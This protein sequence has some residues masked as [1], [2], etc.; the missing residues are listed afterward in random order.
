M[1]AN[2]SLWRAEIK[3]AISVLLFITILFWKVKPLIYEYW[4]TFFEITVWSHFAVWFTEARNIQESSWI[5]YLQKTRVIHSSSIYLRLIGWNPFLHLSCLWQS[6]IDR[7][8][9][10]HGQFI[11][12]HEFFDLL[13]E[14]GK[15]KNVVI[16]NTNWNLC[17]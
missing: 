1:V 8:N 15:I 12:L 2:D 11:I 9:D 6:F 3:Q 10:I 4:K 14:D 17:L 13:L 16:Q 7:G 5:F